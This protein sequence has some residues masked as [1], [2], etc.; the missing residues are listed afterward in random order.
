MS[1]HTGIILGVDDTDHVAFICPDCGKTMKVTSVQTFG[2]L[3][4]VPTKNA[5]THVYVKCVCGHD[6]WRKFY[7]IAET[8]EH[9]THR[10]DGKDKKIN[11]QM[12]ELLGLIQALPE[13][14][15]Q[16]KC[17]HVAS[18]LVKKLHQ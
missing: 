14:E 8:G 2:V 15:L 4:G 11:A 3:R 5:C 1:K 16:S 10:T 17:Q 12:A 7:W 18:Y 9:C 13:S 6:H